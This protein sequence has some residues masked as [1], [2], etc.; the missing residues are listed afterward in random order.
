MNR[1]LTPLARCVALALTGFSS[2]AGAATVNVDT[3]TTSGQVLT[4]ETTLQV[5][6]AGSITTSGKSVELKNATS[7]AGVIVDNRGLIKSTGDRGLDSS[8]SNPSRTYQIIN[9]EGATIDAS[10]QAIRIS[11]DLAGTHVTIDNAG[12]LVSQTDRA[13]MLKDLKTNVQIDITNRATGLIRGVKEDAMRVGNNATITNYGTISSG[14][15]TS[16]DAKFDGIDFDASTGGK[17]ENH[18]TLSGGR[19][20]ITTDAGAELVNYAG[21][22]IIGRNGSGFGSDGNGRVTNYGRITGAYNGLVPDGDGDGVDID[23][24]GWIDN[25]GIIEGTGAG[26]SKDG[27]ANTS[28]GIAMGGGTILNHAGATISGAANA[29]LIDDSATGG[30]PYATHLENFGQILGLGGDAVRIIGEQA[31]SVINGGLISS[32]GGVALDLGGGADSLTLRS[33]SQFVGRV[34]GGAGRDV[35]TLD[36]VGGGSFGNSAHFEWLKVNAGRWT[37]DTQDFSEGGEVLAGAELVNLGRIGGTLGIASGATY[38]GGG[39]VDN[40]DLAA[41]S[42]LAFAVAA[43]GSHSPLLADGHVALDGARLE[44]RASAGTYPNTRHYQVIQAADGV[45][46]RFA[47]VTS[48]FAFLTPTLRYEADSVELDLTRNDVAFADIAD[49]GNG[50]RVAGSISA[51]GS[52]Q[53]YNALVTSST[54]EARDALNQL[55]ATSN[56]SL[57]GSTL[58]STSQ[59]SGAMLGALQSFSGGLGGNLQ[60]S[61][62]VEDGPLLAATGV[63]ADA[64]NLND[65]SA[66]GRLWVQALGSHGNL[67]GTQGGHDLDSDT[68]GAVVGVDWAVGGDWRLGVLGGYSRTD[69]EA[70]SGFEGDVDSL[71]LGVYGLRQDGPVALRLGAAYSRHDGDSKRE[72]AFG[73]FTDHLRGRYDAESFQAFT[74]VGYAM[75]SG[76]VQAEPFAGIGYQYYARDGYDEKG[77]AA[78]LHVDDQDQG[79]LTSTFGVRIARLD[80]LDNGMAFTPRLSVAWRH[81]YGTVDSSTRQSFLSGG[82]AFSVEGSALDRNS[83]LLDAGFDIG[84]SSTQS[85]G[86]GYSGELG[87]NAQNHAIVAQWQMGL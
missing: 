68:R 79:N 62:N 57:A 42:T 7:G 59:V 65:P 60:S 45:S 22:V 71:H 72:V 75:G 30:A 18:G 24:Q 21:G 63:S 13:I 67:D 34:D 56:A 44:V 9:R 37:L 29:I 55:A 1:T 76:N 70:G 38:A 19:H 87:G 52:P 83:L 47:S 33:G 32:T 14:D 15:M 81:V 77:G 4:G 31:D 46:G 41:G 36:D 39:H 20:G 53:L 2:F 12:T 40:L 25:H 54:G 16:A 86:L 27:S 80:T 49:N 26:G 28:E 74:E 23:G 58:G 48:N 84:L 66:R 61:L 43:D 50:A 10:K 3:A 69:L 17:V 35:L 85:I 82:S 6:S 73:G 11:G 8:G 51:Q 5:G 64:R 78:A